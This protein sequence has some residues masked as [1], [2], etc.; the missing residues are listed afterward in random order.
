MKFSNIR[1]V[2]RE[3]GWGG[4]DWIYLAQDRNQGQ[5]QAYPIKIRALPCILHSQSIISTPNAN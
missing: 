1:M 2:L 5:A 4:M 3:V